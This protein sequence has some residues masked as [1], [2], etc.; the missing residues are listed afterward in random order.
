MNGT[1]LYDSLQIA[2]NFIEQAEKLADTQEF[3]AAFA[4]L[5]KAK[6]YAFNNDDLLDNIQSQHETL[7]N[8][9]RHYIR[10]LEEKVADQFNQ[11]PFDGQKA[12][13]LLQSLRYYDS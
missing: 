6:S 5:D 8:A 9:R 12:R 13:E 11:E 3:E 7:N 10:Q 1:N 4:A 2:S